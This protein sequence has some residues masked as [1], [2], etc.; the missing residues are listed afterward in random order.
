MSRK[1]NPRQQTSRPPAPRAAADA[2][3]SGDNN[4]G[5]FHPPA[6]DESPVEF[7]DSPAAM[8]ADGLFEHWA[9]NADQECL[10]ELI[11]RAIHRDGSNAAD[12]AGSEAIGLI[13]QR[14]NDTLDGE[15]VY[16]AF[17][18]ALTKANFSLGSMKFGNYPAP[19]SLPLPAGPQVPKDVL[20][21]FTTR[22]RDLVQSTVPAAAP[23]IRRPSPRMAGIP[24]PDL[25]AGTVNVGSTALSI[26]DAIKL[27][28]SLTIAVVELLRPAEGFQWL[29]DNADPQSRSILVDLDGERGKLL[30]EVGGG[31]L[32][33]EVI[34]I[35]SKG[36]DENAGKYLA[37]MYNYENGFNE[38]QTGS[39]DM[40]VA[41]FKLAERVRQ[42]MIA[43]ASL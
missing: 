5:E 2:P 11:R 38:F 13:Q 21:R 7:A 16:P 40:N 35:P 32:Q 15:S 37:R 1:N 20:N 24:Y 26:S 23:D 27:R 18:G 14:L 22:R 33:G 8:S 17:A 10:A 39:D 9:T 12:V 4:G 19:L 42:F 41:K 36:P 29:N 31:R 6:T 43:K 30:Q 3:A 34:Q 25:D 28:D